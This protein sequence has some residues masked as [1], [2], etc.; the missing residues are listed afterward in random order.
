LGGDALI[1]VTLAG[2]GSGALHDSLAT[3][4]DLAS[5]NLRTGLGYLLT[6]LEDRMRYGFMAHLR[7]CA[8]ALAVAGA[9]LSVLAGAANAATFNVSNTEQ[10][11][12]AV[13]SANANKEANTI[14]LAGE[15]YLPLETVTFTNTSGTQTIAGPSGT[16]RLPPAKIDG[17]DAKNKEGENAELFVVNPGATVTFKDVEIAHGGGPGVQAISDAGTLSV[18]NSTVAGNNGDG[19]IVAPGAK[20]TGTNST[21]SDGANFGIID[22]GTA[23][24][25]NSTIAFNAEVGIENA[26][27]LNLTNTIVADNTVGNCVGKANTSDHSLDSDGSCGVGTLSDVNPKLVTGLLQNQGGSTPYH[28]IEAGSPAIEAGDTATCTTVDQRGFARPAI[29]G[30]PCSIG[31]FEYY[32]APHFYSNG[33]LVEEEEPKPVIEWG[34]ATLKSTAGATVTCHYVGGGEVATAGVGTTLTLATFDCESSTCPFVASVTA[35][36]LPWPEHLEMTGGRAERVVTEGVKLHNA[37]FN[38]AKEESSEKFS[39][40]PA[41][42][43]HKGTSALHPSFLE[44]DTESG[45]LLKEGAATV[46]AKLSGSFKV[47]GYLGQELISTKDP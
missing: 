4:L 21:F 47:L 17:A 5:T 46:S 15:V 41:P 19:I 23:S 31:A 26:G 3:A 6:E 18:E 45:N 30:K 11:V 8:V 9:S 24:F 34:V 40:T 13:S 44:F 25:F 27:T 7:A 42:I 32:P 35:E 20:L 10:F 1:E 38:G 37:C 28:A 39:G 12:S 36:G 16:T 43:S 14:V 2:N 33:A 29:V 22:D